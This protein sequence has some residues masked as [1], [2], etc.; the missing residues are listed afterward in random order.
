MSIMFLNYIHEY[1]KWSNKK[2]TAVTIL[3]WACIFRDFYHGSRR[4]IAWTNLGGTEIVTIGEK[5]LIPCTGQI[6]LCG[7]AT[8][9]VHYETK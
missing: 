5:K 6:Y 4:L 1:K 2:C 3:Y 7:L 9:S 8:V